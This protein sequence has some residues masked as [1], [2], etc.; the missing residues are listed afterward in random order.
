MDNSTYIRQGIELLASKQYSEAITHFEKHFAF[1]Q[2]PLAMS[3]Y[4]LC[5]ATVEGRIN[6]AK[7]L[8]LMALKRDPKNPDMYY[9]FGKVLFLEGKKAH[10]I[11]IFFKGLKYTKDGTHPLID[12]ELIAIGKRRR[13]FISSLPRAHFINKYVGKMTYFIS[14][15][16]GASAASRAVDVPLTAKG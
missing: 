15:K 4:G 16:F 6:Y 11:K 5:I 12:N 9:N 14:N 2:H 1:A 3:F 7:T 10:A 13:P 8:C